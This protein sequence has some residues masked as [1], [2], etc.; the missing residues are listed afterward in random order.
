MPILG[1][2]CLQAVAVGVQEQKGEE[3]WWLPKYLVLLQL[4][5]GSPKIVQ[6]VV[7]APRRIT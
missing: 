5:G 6:P 2:S 3:E 1:A 4:H 7:I